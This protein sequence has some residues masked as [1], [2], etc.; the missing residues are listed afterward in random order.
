MQKWINVLFF[1]T[2]IFSAL[3]CTNSK[4]N[5]EAAEDLLR[6]D[7]MKIHDE[8]MPMMG[9]LTGLTGEVKKILQQDTLLPQEEQQK[10]E[11]VVKEMEIAEEG[12]MDWMAG[13]RQPESLRAT[14]G[15]EEIMAYLN[16]EKDKITE[17]STRIKSGIENGKTIIGNYQKK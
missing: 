5:G 15:H 17:V 3:Q 9:E 14:M 7:L 4:K 16:T 1:V 13:F 6:T 12:M 10:L 11:M 2:L 8:V